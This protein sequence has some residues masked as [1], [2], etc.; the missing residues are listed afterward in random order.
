M[1]KTKAEDLIIAKVPRPMLDRAMEIFHHLTYSQTSVT[2]ISCLR[3]PPDWP[4]RD[5]TFRRNGR[6][7]VMGLRGNKFFGEKA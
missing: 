4:K 5:I 2:E 7:F 3:V 6:R 1:T